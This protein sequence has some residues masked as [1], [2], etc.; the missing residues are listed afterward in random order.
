MNDRRSS[1]RWR[2][3]FTL[4]A[5]IA[6]SPLR[7]ASGQN[8][9]ETPPWKAGAAAVDIT[10]EGPVWLAGFPKRTAPSTGVAT[11]IFTKA[12]AI[13]DSSGSRAGKADAV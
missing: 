8:A 1:L 6:L 2:C 10:P 12:L 11:P 13:E 4:A 5:L 3:R 9:A 7:H